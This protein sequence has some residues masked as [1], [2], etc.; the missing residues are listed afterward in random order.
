MPDTWHWRRAVP[1]TLRTG[2]LVAASDCSSALCEYSH[3]AEEQS[4]AASELVSHTLAPPPPS[5]CPQMLSDLGVAGL[6]HQR[7]CFVGYENHHPNSVKLS[8]LVMRGFSVYGC[9]KFDFVAGVGRTGVVL[10]R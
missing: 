1:G 3:K 8:L 6:A 9:G 4:L 10:A 7:I 5:A 2:I